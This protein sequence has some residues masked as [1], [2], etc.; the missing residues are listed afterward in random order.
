MNE[1]PPFLKT[2]YTFVRGKSQLY[3]IALLRHAR[4]KTL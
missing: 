2:F 1:L 3:Q 4:S